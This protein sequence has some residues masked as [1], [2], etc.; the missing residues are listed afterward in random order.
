MNPQREAISPDESPA[1]DYV[2]VLVGGGVT[3][4]P[5]WRLS[6]WPG[7]QPAV[8]EKRREVG[9]QAGVWERVSAGMSRA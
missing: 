9:S 6:L 2:G 4:T 5:D 8:G 7:S 3:Q 1:D